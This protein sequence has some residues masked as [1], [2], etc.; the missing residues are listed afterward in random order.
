MTWQPIDTAPKDTAVLTW[1]GAGLFS[2][3]ERIDHPADAGKKNQREIWCCVDG[4]ELI[5]V[6]HWTPLPA[7]PE[8]V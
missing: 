8:V 7:P 6:T 4:C 1:R 2:V 3:A 5:N